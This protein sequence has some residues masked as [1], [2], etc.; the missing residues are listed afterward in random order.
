MSD[1]Y[2]DFRLVLLR[3]V[4]TATHRLVY[5]VDRPMADIAFVT[6][7][8]AKNQLS[9]EVREV[10]EVGITGKVRGAFKS[11]LEGG[12]VVAEATPRRD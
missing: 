9:A 4:R 12:A 1:R 5:V 2:C 3:E 7:S 11:R 6:T 10:Y 8:M